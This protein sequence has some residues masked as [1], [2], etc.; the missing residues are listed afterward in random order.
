MKKGRKKKSNK[1][2][3]KRSWVRW[4]FTMILLVLFY[5]LFRIY[6]YPNSDAVIKMIGLDPQAAISAE[7]YGGAIQG[8]VAGTAV[9]ASVFI[10]NRQQKQVLRDKLYD[11]RLALYSE[12][13]SAMQDIEHKIIDLFRYLPEETDFI[14]SRKK[15]EELSQL[16]MEF[17]RNQDK[18][19]IFLSK[20]LYELIFTWGHYAIEGIERGHLYVDCL[21]YDSIPVLIQLQNDEEKYRIKLVKASK[22]VSEAIREELGIE[23]L[24]SDLRSTVP[25]SNIPKQYFIENNLLVEPENYK[26]FADS[27][28]INTLQY[29]HEQI[30]EAKKKQEIKTNFKVKNPPQSDRFIETASMK[31]K[32]EIMNYA[33]NGMIQLYE[34]KLKNKED[35]KLE[36]DEFSK[37]LAE[38]I[39]Q[40]IIEKRKKA[41]AESSK[42]I[43]SI[44]DEITRVAMNLPKPK[45]NED[46]SRDIKRVVRE[47]RYQF[48]LSK[49]HQALEEGNIEHIYDYLQNHN[50]FFQHYQTLKTDEEKIAFIIKAY[51]PDS[52]L[53]NKNNLALKIYSKEKFM[54]KLL[55]FLSEYEAVL[56]IKEQFDKLQ[57]KM[58]EKS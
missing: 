39:I 58:T 45:D 8:A 27:V 57:T 11:K 26:G 55:D 40:Y 1:S 34:D 5:L 56:C 2:F 38:N 4:T 32:E 48:F 28:A 6:L 41:L 37:S 33:E 44:V 24:E 22:I 46:I 30:V 15:V 49:I 29:L 19:S 10:F 31:L 9:I 51:F 53:L 16:M 13:Y 12:I 7:V 50:H 42:E 3:G 54:E 14:K 23:A 18:H 20:E 35:H 43:I 25:Y 47:G 36:N 21:E 52:S 17:R